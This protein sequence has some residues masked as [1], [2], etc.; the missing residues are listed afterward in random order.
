V[1]A[2]VQTSPRPW[3]AGRMYGLLLVP[4]LAFIAVFFLLPLGNM[5][6]LSLSGPASGLAN[7]R[8]IIAGG[9]YLAT[10]AITLRIAFVVTIL[11]LL[12][13]YPLAYFIAHR[14]GWWLRLCLGLVLVP[15]WT[16]TVI[17]T[18]GWMIV[19]Q[20]DGPLNRVLLWLGITHSPIAFLPGPVGVYVGMVQILLP[21]MV[22]PLVASMRAVDRTLLHA[23]EILGANPFRNFLHIF[24]PLTLPGVTAGVLLVFITA[25]GFFVTPALLG[26]PH[27]TMAAVLID[28]V[29]ETYLDWPLASALSVLLLVLTG[30]LYLVYSRISGRADSVYAGA[31]R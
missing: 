14:R 19:F 3:L 17:R 10:F 8:H 29:A 6:A 15:F 26:G 28:Q 23:G 20:R 11:C 16:S 27:Q 7:Y 30:A 21:F 2:A 9:P 13:G 24:L 22:L 4:P 18:C 12:I 25:L 31:Q 1:T 5:L